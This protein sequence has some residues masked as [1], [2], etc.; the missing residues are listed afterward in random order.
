MY[1]GQLTYE[2][3]AKSVLACELG[4]QKQHVESK[5]QL[6][7]FYEQIMKSSSAAGHVITLDGDQVML[8]LEDTPAGE[9]TIQQH[10]LEDLQRELK[11]QVQNEPSLSGVKRQQRLINRYVNI[12]EAI[13][14][15]PETSEDAVFETLTVS[16]VHE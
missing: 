7:N 2:G 3:L 13:E 6:Q 4:F 8:M 14:A 16:S 15:L 11:K 9:A 10:L 12:L 5:E 1:V